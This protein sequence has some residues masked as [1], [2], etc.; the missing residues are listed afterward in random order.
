MMNLIWA[1]MFSL[2]FAQEK[3]SAVLYDL[4]SNQ[5]K[6]LYTLSIEA[7]SIDGGTRLQTTY[8]DLEGKIIAQEKGFSIGDDL[9][10]YT[11]E[12][13]QTNEKGHIEVRDGRVYFEYEGPGGKTKKDDE[14]VKG[15]VLCVA[16]FT[17]FVRQNWDSL[18]AG[19][20][21]PVR[22][23]VWDRRETVGFTLEKMGESDH[24]GKKWLEIRMKPTSFVI[25]AI[26]D[27]IHLWY[28]VEGKNLMLMKGRVLPKIQGSSHSDQW[29][30]L[31]AET[32][33]TKD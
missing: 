1:L 8:R 11:V 2:S 6:K 17:A 3:S 22:Y 5:S 32:V 25:A 18:V 28:S 20:A 33:Y 19:K 21:I 26:V 15:K 29:K 4:K 16:N 30:D 24:S 27:P 14:K 10:E 9:K 12:R 13:P 7:T 31:D 23:A